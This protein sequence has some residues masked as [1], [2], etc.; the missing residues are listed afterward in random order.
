MNRLARLSEQQRVAAIVAV[1]AVLGT[2]LAV[3]TREEPGRTI[4]EGVELA[5]ADPFAFQEQDPDE[6]L[7]RG[8]KGLSHPLYTLSPGGVEA[9]A[10]RTLRFEDQIAD[11]ASEEG[12]DAS[13]LEALVFLESAG[14][15]AAVAGP[16]PES[17]TGLGQILPDTATDLLDMSLDLEKSKRLTRE[18]S[19]LEERAMGADGPKARVRAERELKALSAERR[20]VDE[21]FDPDAALAGAARYLAI[22]EEHFGRE[23]LA[24]ASYHMG[25]GNLDSVIEVYLAPEPV[26]PTTAETVSQNDL[27]YAQIYFDSTPVDNPRAYRELR[28]LGDDSRHYLFRLEAARHAIALYREDPSELRRLAELHGSRASREEVLRP[29]D[30][31]ER[32]EDA[33]ALRD[34][35]ESEELVSLRREATGIGY[36][37]D[38]AMGELAGEVDEEPS[39]YRGLR[40][41]AL[42]AVAYIARQARDITGVRTTLT[43]TSSVRDTRY[44]ELLQDSNTQAAD[45]YSLH[46]TGFAFDV[47]RDLSGRSEEAVV[48]VL[49]RLRALNVL[50]WVYEPGAIHVTVGP[51]AEALL[52]D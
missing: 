49:E 15:P 11:A 36:R 27:S 47:S 30:E 42:A 52:A 35:Y 1:C 9:T 8:S 22:A 28:A 46:T 39:L 29:S 34:A 7:E 6:L 33:D 44:H 26:A 18:I 12:V 23:D 41:E 37:V 45:G 43:L 38:R 51:E 48:A 24:A 31:T 10:E 13:T 19:R 32:F 14:R 2:V 21:R 16:S 4:A 40:P 25:I 20:R 3:V 5:Q 17:A 50:D